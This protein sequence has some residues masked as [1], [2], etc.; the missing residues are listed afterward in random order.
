[1]AM[2]RASAPRLQIARVLRQRG[3]DARGIAMAG[4]IQAEQP[5]SLRGE[6]RVLAENI[7]LS[8]IR[9]QGAGHGTRRACQGRH[10]AHGLFEIR[11][12]F[13]AIRAG[14]QRVRGLRRRR[15][16]RSYRLGMVNAA[17]G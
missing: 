9:L 5:G 8:Q 2:P 4:G 3:A 6:Q 13:E 1:M 7:G 17:P 15:G 12:A 14:I 10:R 16:T 11:A